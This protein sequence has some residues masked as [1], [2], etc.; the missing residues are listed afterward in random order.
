MRQFVV[1][2]DAATVR[3]FLGFFF[4]IFGLP[5]VF[6]PAYA[7]K[8]ADP[9]PS[10][11]VPSDLGAFIVPEG[12]TVEISQFNEEF[13]RQ[14]KRGSRMATADAFLASQDAWQKEKTYS[15]VL[16]EAR[17]G[18]P[19]AMVNVG[20]FSLAGW[21]TQSNA[22]NALYWLH[23]AA[24][25][26]Y[27]R[28]FYDLGILYFKGCGVKRDEAEAFHFFTLGA[29]AG[30]APAQVNLG[31][32]Y[33][34]GLGT[35]QDHAA[36]AHWYRQAAEAGEAQAQFNLADLY[37]RGE[38]VPEDEKA[39][40][41]WFQKAALQGHTGA[42]IMAGSMLFAGRGAPKDLLGAYFWIF[43]AVSE[44]D[45][46]GIP[47]LRILESQMA[48]VEIEEARAHAESFTAAHKV[49]SDVALSH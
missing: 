38:G 20:L 21:G 34:R 12:N 8:K 32:F 44:G 23:A 41:G 39:A 33:D 28:A 22:G 1:T 37:L 49:A 48:R 35:A 42:Q 3:S 15:V 4:L 19:A 5:A 43:A 36:A 13:K 45:D 9:A 29:A 27:K 30:H 17:K 31:Y 14:T 47:T 18:N 24:D 40:F 11:C 16:K 46:R 7:Q 26:G 10:A 25:R 2:T 6:C